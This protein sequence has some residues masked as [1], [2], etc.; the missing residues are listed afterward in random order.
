VDV[1]VRVDDDVL[2][3]ASA[4]VPARPRA[5][6]VSP[7]GAPDHGIPL[8]LAASGFLA[9]HEASADAAAPKL[10]SV[11]PRV[12]VLV[13]SSPG[14]VAASL[15]SIRS[16]EHGAKLPVLVCATESDQALLTAARREHFAILVVAPPDDL[17]RDVVEIVRQL[18][19]SPPAEGARPRLLVMDDNVAVQALARSVFDRAGYDVRVVDGVREALALVH[20]GDAFDA[21]LLDLNLPDGNGFEVLRAIR[22]RSDVPV[23][24][25]SAMGQAALVARAFELGATDYIEKPFDPRAL[26]ARVARHL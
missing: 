3:D 4:L 22:E 17:R 25:F 11:A 26:R 10:A 2:A 12:V 1:G 18:S 5:L 8:A 19:S 16:T 7:A 20:D 24:I 21:A 23:L 9:Y 6:I 13:P 14:E 15:R